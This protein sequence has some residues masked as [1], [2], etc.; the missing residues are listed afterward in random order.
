VFAFAITLLAVSLEVPKSFDELLETMK[1]FVGFALTF[2]ILFLFWYRQYVFFRKYGIDDRPI[3][4]LNGVLLFSVLFFIYPFKFMSYLIVT[5]IFDFNDQSLHRIINID[6]MPELLSLY[7]F[8]IGL[9]NGTLGLMYRHALK[10]RLHL[11]LNEAEEDEA[12]RQY[13]TG[14]LSITAFTLAIAL[15]FILP[16]SLSSFSVLPVFILAILTRAM[17]RKHF[18]LKKFLPKA[19]PEKA[20]E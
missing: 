13:L 1:G 8:G 5:M 6:K 9:M 11:Q 14:I 17:K 16:P 3:I 18:P 10:Y 2:G 15:L 20:M 12:I 19:A 7:F 4:A